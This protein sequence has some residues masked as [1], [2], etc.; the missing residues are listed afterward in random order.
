MTDRCQC[1]RTNH[2]HAE[3]PCGRV[4]PARPVELVPLGAE[5]FP[6]PAGTRLCEECN[7]LIAAHEVEV[8]VQQKAFAFTKA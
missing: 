5:A 4:P 3:R 7:R 6:A 1:Q 2:D 8:K